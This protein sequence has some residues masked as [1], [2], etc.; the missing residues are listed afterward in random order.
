M[1]NLFFFF[2]FS[3]FIFCC[4]VCNDGEEYLRRLQASWLDMVH[5]VL[6]NL[7]TLKKHH[8]YH[9]LHKDIN[10]Y[11]LEKRKLLPI[12]KEVRKNV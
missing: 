2:F 6:Y 3:F 8:K 10:P 7:S 1:L 5:L 12:P 4:T 9:H 11:V